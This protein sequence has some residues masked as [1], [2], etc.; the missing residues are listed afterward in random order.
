MASETSFGGSAWRIAGWGFA[1]LILL[2]PFVAMQFTREVN[3]TGSDF[4]FAAVV[5]GGVG[6]LFELAV[7]VSDNRAFRAGVALA[8]L[9]SFLNV[10]I[11]AAVGMIGDEDDPFNLL[12]LGVILIALVSSAVGRFRAPGMAL[13]MLIAA[14]AQFAVGLIGMLIDVR[15]GLFSATFAAIW[16]ASAAMFRRAGGSERGSA[17]TPPSTSG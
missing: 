10:W 16:L 8:L 7:K 1:L 13:A 15:D 17:L 5:I 12:F 11:N 3:W 14:I 4:L 9:A 2:A 6:L